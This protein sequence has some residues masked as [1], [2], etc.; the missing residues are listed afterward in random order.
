[1]NKDVEEENPF[2]S[3]VAEVSMGERGKHAPILVTWQSVYCS[4]T[5]STG[6]PCR[7]K[8]TEKQVLQ[9]VSGFAKPGTITAII[10]SS[11]AG[12]S[13]LLDILSGRKNLGT[14]NGDIL[15]NGVKRNSSFKRFSAYVTQEDILLPTLTVYETLMFNVRLKMEREKGLSKSERDAKRHSRVMEMIEELGL[16]KT[17]NVRVGDD[18]HRGISGGEKKRLSIGCE[19]I[20]DPSLLFLD[21]PTTGLDAY[22]SQQVI[23]TL[24]KL[25]L[26]GRTVICTLHQ[27]RSSIFDMFDYLCCLSEGRVVYFGLAKDSVK[28][29]EQEAGRICSPYY[30]PADFI[31]DLAL[32]D[33]R[34]RFALRMNRQPPSQ[35]SKKF[36]AEG[37]KLKGSVSLADLFEKSEMNSLQSRHL[38]ELLT[39]PQSSY[40]PV[41]KLVDQV[42]DE[43]VPIIEGN[44]IPFVIP[45][46]SRF[47]VSWPYQL[48]YLIQRQFRHTSRT[49]ATSIAVLF[50]AVFMSLLVGSIYHGTLTGGSESDVFSRVSNRQAALFFSMT[51]LAFGQMQAMMQF[52]Q[53][54]NL[55]LKEKAAGMYQISAYYLAKMLSDIP[56]LIIGPLIFCS[57]SYWLI[58]FQPVFINFLLYIAIVIVFVTTMTSMFVFVGCLAPNPQVAQIIASLMTVIFFLFAGFY[59]AADTIPEYYI[60]LKYLSPFK[61]AFNALLLNEFTGLCL[62]DEDSSG[63]PA[64]CYGDNWLNCPNPNDPEA[65]GCLA[66]KDSLNIWQD[67]VVLAGMILFYRLLGY[68]CLRALHNQHR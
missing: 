30:N 47:A 20:A 25:A 66:G 58:G 68:I 51:N 17:V 63:C 34:R 39:S 22:N 21:E 28:Y 6:P 64:A 3:P 9:D 24:K 23:Y 10:G 45:E 37:S 2:A 12:K 53:E 19:M 31:I 4:L 11:G 8:H 57:I 41:K 52:T 18:T 48:V 27:P 15:V 5:E 62:C 49:P 38:Q 65:F 14:V 29:F 35:I 36:E 43:D 55:M 32:E 46:I 33:E 26:A 60:W 42:V 61:Y 13:T 7:R 16:E 50:Q 54:R 56:S 40:D 1:M 44:G 67:V 59:V